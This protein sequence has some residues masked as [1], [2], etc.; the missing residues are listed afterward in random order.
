M[1]TKSNSIERFDPYLKKFL[2][3]LA[4][5]EYVEKEVIVNTEKE[6]KVDNKKNKTTKGGKKK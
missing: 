3:V 2:H 5:K 6:K 1:F 4:N